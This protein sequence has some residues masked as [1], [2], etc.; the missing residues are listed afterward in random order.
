[1]ERFTGVLWPVA[2]CVQAF[3]LVAR[4]WKVENLVRST[5]RRRRYAGFEHRRYLHQSTQSQRWRKKGDVDNAQN[6]SIGVSR[7]GRSIKIH[8]VVDGLGNPC[9]LILTGGQVHDGIMLKPALE[10]LDISENTILADKAYG[11]EENRQYISDQ[12]VQYCVLPKKNAVNVWECDY[13]H[14]KERHL[15]ECFF[16]KI[17]DYRRVAMRFEKLARR[18]LGMVHLASCLVWLA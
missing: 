1:M 14:Y 4:K 6:Q 7:G 15:V 3:C 10:Q 11:S 12:G 2:D 13:F 5:T 17:K 16:M 18:F 9:I 8:A